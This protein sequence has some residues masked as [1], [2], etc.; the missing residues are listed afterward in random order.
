MGQRIALVFSCLGL[1]LAFSDL[2]TAHA[3][4]PDDVVI[5]PF[6]RTDQNPASEVIE[7]PTQAEFSHAFLHRVTA[8]VIGEGNFAIPQIACTVR[9]RWL[10][11]PHAGL[12]AVLRAYYAPDRRP[13]QWQIDIVRQIF[14]GELPCPETWWYALSLQ[15]TSYWTPHDRVATVVRRDA[16]YQIWIYER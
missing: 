3:T 2:P 10:E 7:S 15:D 16:K 9:N 8:R 12:D 1:F 6:A 13:Q 11:N 5:S 4:I 14:T